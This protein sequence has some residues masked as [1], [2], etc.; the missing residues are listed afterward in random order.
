M[1]R[2]KRG[3]RL[4]ILPTRAARHGRRDGAQGISRELCGGALKAAG[5]SFFDRR[6]KNSTKRMVVLPVDGKNQK[7][8]YKSVDCNSLR[9]YHRIDRFQ[10]A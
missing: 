8:Y 6:H 3:K 5:R 4:S 1:T 7:H 2:I 10:Y 9:H